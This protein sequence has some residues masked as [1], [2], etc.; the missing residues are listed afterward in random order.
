MLNLMRKHASSWMIKVLLFAIVV[1]FSFWGVG[2]FRSRQASKVATV[3]GEVIHVADY[4]RAYNN[5][6][7][8]YRQQFGTSLNDKMIE[9]LQIKRQVQAQ[10]A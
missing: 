4:Q 6:L 1:V 2:S 9:M 8:Q 3:N 10:T 7:D 5:L